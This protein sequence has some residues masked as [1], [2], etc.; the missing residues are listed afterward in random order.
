MP[1]KLDNNKKVAKNTMYLYV[2]M[3]MVM[4]IGV[5]TSRVILANLGVEDYGLYNIVGGVAAMF[6]FFSSSLTNASQR[7]LAVELGRNDKRQACLVFNQHLLLYSLF[8]VVV[9]IAAETFG[10]WLLYTKLVIPP[11]RFFAAV[12]VY[13]LTVVSLCLTLS[14]IVFLSSVV[15]HEDFHIFTYVSIFEVFAKL[16]IAYLIST[17]NSDKLIFYAAMLLLVNFLQQ[18]CYIVYCH[19]HYE[20]CRLKKVFDKEIVRSTGAM[21]SWNM[22]GTA[23]VAINDYGVNIL[24]NMFFGPVVNAARSLS[25]QVGSAVFGFSNNMFQAVNPQITKTYA[26]GDYNALM[27]LFYN[28]S[29]YSF[30]LM[31]LFALPVI[32]VCKNL[33]T[34]WLVEVPDYTVPFMSLL[35][36][37]NLIYSLVNPIWAVALAT[38][39]MKRYTLIGT[40]VLLL[41]FPLSYA[42]LK[43]GL[44][45]VYVFVVLIIVRLTY[46]CST[47]NVIKRYIPLTIH[48]YIA[49]VIWPVLK[50]IVPSVLFAI[51][52]TYVLPTASWFSLLYCAVVFGASACCTW[53]FGMTQSEQQLAITSIKRKNIQ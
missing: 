52:L 8:I 48:R 33:L 26:V 47:F 10:L 21:I 13:Q 19:H 42:V 30:F 45:P 46:L 43:C 41:V 18:I 34:L 6:G 1:N 35:L 29:K 3:A 25:Y 31:W 23:I 53:A 14:G 16:L 27:S 5:Y 39:Q 12:C 4:V 7:F 24:L 36:I 49:K 51:G 17:C 38:M 44:S 50:V 28:S 37:H 22:V 32:C 40:S 20:E 11:A 2:R 9:V 15:A